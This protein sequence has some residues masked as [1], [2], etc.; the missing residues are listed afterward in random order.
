[1][2]SMNNID[3]SK[4]VN[5]ILGEIKESK[6]IANV[7]KEVLK[8]YCMID[9][10]QNEKIISL[11]SRKTKSDF[12]MKRRGKG[13]IIVSSNYRSF[14]MQDKFEEIIEIR[15]NDENNVVL[16]NVFQ[17]EDGKGIAT[18]G[19]N[20]KIAGN[21]QYTQTIGRM[22][23]VDSNTLIQVANRT[24]LEMFINQYDLKRSE[25]FCDLYW[26]MTSFI[27]SLFV[28]PKGLYKI[29]IND[30]YFKEEFKELYPKLKNKINEI[31]NPKIF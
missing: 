29:Q 4:I 3:Y 25:V 20:W 26:D 15:V 16:S 27:K 22:L 8:N 2:V 30:G 9:V 5:F 12:I 13:I 19:S 11:K 1:M 6:D 23:Y 28:E 24:S 10:N 31:L 21:D 18:V 7:L 14:T 17:T